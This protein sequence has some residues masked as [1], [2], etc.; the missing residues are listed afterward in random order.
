VLEVQQDRH[1][2]LAGHFRDAPQL[3][4]VAVDLE[5]LLTDPNGAGTE[6]SLDVFPGIGVVRDLVGEEEKL[7]GMR[8]RQRHDGAVFSRSTRVTASAIARR[9]Q[10]GSGDAKRALMLNEKRISP[11][12]VLNML[13][14]IDDG[15]VRSG[16][17]SADATYRAGSDPG[18]GG[19][20][21]L[22]AL[23]R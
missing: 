6:L 1:V 10:D 18:G 15:L 14:H 11:T 23:D 7:S 20:K 19:A 8:L 4:R 17:G 22:P 9:H 2:E 12:A 3:G 5:L 13:M 21:K 16:G